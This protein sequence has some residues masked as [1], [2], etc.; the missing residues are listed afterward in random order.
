MATTGIYSTAPNVAP[1]A[2]SGGFA[3]TVLATASVGPGIAP[4]TQGIGTAYTGTLAAGTY[5]VGGSF[6]ATRTV[7][8]WASNDFLQFFINNGNNDIVDIPQ[9]FL[10]GNNS[11]GTAAPY[12]MAATVSGLIILPTAQA[13]SW[14]V[15]A[16]YP[17]ATGYD[18][19]TVTVANPYYIKIG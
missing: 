14:Y 3:P 9:I 17:S 13:L 15:A 19:T 7:S 4:G 5:L 16:V 11:I 1:V 8:N 2:A 10:S 12:A 18:R 6:S